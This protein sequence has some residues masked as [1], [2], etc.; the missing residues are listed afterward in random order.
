MGSP[1]VIRNYTDCKGFFRS[2]FGSVRTRNR[3][4]WLHVWHYILRYKADFFQIHFCWWQRIY[5]LSLTPFSETYELRGYVVE[6]YQWYTPN[7]V[8][9]HA[10]CC[11]VLIICW[12]FV[13]Q[14]MALWKSVAL[15]MRLLR[16]SQPRNGRNRKDAARLWGS[17]PLGYVISFWKKV[18]SWYGAQIFTCVVAPISFTLCDCCFVIEVPRIKVPKDRGVAYSCSSYLV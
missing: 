17:L 4:V 14:S 5:S 16:T 18:I 15:W 2:A 12:S 6:G 13:D 8:V 3:L 9:W 10:E 7:L 11:C 1:D